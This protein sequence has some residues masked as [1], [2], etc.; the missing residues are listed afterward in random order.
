M[1]G[2]STGASELAVCIMMKKT[3]STML[4]SIRGIMSTSSSPSSLALGQSSRAGAWGSTVVVS[5][6][7]ATAVTTGA[8]AAGR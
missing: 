5:P 8:G 6:D 2:T 7:G 3:S 4:M 1:S